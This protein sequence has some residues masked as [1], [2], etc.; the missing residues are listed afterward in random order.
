MLS[1]MIIVMTVPASQGVAATAR[2]SLNGPLPI[3][4]LIVTSTRSVFHFEEDKRDMQ[5]PASHSI[6]DTP[7]NPWSEEL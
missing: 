7:R 3:M 4:S 5:P 6:S 2:G 1:M